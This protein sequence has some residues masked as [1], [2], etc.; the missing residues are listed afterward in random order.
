MNFFTSGSK[1]LFYRLATKHVTALCEKNANSNLRFHETKTVHTKEDIS[2][3]I[4]FE[5]VSI[6][7]IK[8]KSPNGKQ[9]LILERA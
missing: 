8:P 5:K 6:E 1:L 2:E 7:M 3:T 4:H 9:W